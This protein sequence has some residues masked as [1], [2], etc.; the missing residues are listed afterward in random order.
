M[1]TRCRHF[2]PQAVH[3]ASLTRRQPALQAA[4]DLF[5]KKD[6]EAALLCYCRVWRITRVHSDARAD[7]AAA[8]AL[9]H[10]IASCL[11]HLEEHNEAQEWYA[12]AIAAF[13]A[14]QPPGRIG[15]MLSGDPNEQRI[16][17]SEERM[18]RAARGLPPTG[19]WLD[20]T[21][22]RVEAP[23]EQHGEQIESTVPRAA[24]VERG[25]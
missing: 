7:E 9:L 22:R 23:R 24:V 20:G 19:E 16:R 15:K 25:L 11:H 2:L 4:R 5:F 14:I 12:R 17:F 6:F 18:E 1:E 8:G 13:R 3:L 10:N 21:G